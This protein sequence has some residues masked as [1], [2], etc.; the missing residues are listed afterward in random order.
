MIH[1]LQKGRIVTNQKWSTLLLLLV[2]VSWPAM[3]VSVDYDRENDFSRYKTF[4]WREGS[5]AR[6]EMNEKRIR[7]AVNA[8]LEAAGLVQ[9]EGK[10]D[11]YVVSHVSVKGKTRV[12]VE[13][14]GYGGYWSGY[15]T[16]VVH[17][18]E[19]EVGT[20][21]V[22]MLDGATESLVWRGLAQKQ[23]K[24]KGYHSV[25][26]EKLINKIVGKMLR[27]YPPGR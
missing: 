19:I 10:A 1:L 11:L 12:D 2:L 5:P 20:L 7:D 16:S 27:N 3:A 17:V 23:L 13:E 15:Y 18:R 9:V 8:K 25:E 4:A 24:G 26:A 21:V 14:V 22:D 6:S